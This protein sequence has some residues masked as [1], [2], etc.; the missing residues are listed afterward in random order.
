MNI[1]VTGSN[2]FIGSH[3]STYLKENGHYVIGL[4][5]KKLPT[6]VVDEYICCDMHS[7]EVENIVEQLNVDNI[8]AV[9]HLA[10]DMRKEPYGVEVVE[11]NCAGT[12]RLLELCEKKGIKVFVQLSSLPV[13][14]K[15]VEHPITEQH[16]LKP[17]NG[18][19]CNESYGRTSG[20]LC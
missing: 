5:R 2:G 14:G 11:H 13:I 10:A 20:K 1:L 7:E 4:G 17:P 18:I 15:P 9:V 8:D 3:V 16:S 19:S 6:S 12:Q